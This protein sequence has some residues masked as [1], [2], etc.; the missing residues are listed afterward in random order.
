MVGREEKHT[1]ATKGL[2]VSSMQDTTAEF[3][4]LHHRPQ[5]LYLQKGT[6]RRNP[7]SPGMPVTDKDFGG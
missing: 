5:F 1:C 6:A 7:M 4:S 3:L 2:G